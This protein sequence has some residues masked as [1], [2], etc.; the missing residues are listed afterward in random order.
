MFG[1]NKN[2]VFLTSN[3]EKQSSRRVG[4]VQDRIS[5]QTGVPFDYINTLIIADNRLPDFDTNQQIQ[6]AHRHDERTATKSTS[7]RILQTLYY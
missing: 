1:F 6:F 4:G 3:T 7:N 2:T 5:R